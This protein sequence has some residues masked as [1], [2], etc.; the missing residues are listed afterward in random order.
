MQPDKAMM[1]AMVK[2][3]SKLPSATV[4]LPKSEPSEMP[5]NSALLF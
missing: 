1:A 3:A 4:F 2:F 5:K